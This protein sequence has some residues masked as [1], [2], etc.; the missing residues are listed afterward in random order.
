[1]MQGDGSVRVRI[2]NHAVV[3]RNSSVA[4]VPVFVEESYA[5]STVTERA[6]SVS[7]IYGSTPNEATR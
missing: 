2:H 7:L 1:M 4:V 5:T 3:V 6:R